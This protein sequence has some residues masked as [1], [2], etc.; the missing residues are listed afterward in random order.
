RTAATWSEELNIGSVRVHDVE[1]ATFIVEVFRRAM[2]SDPCSVGGPR[3]PTYNVSFRVQD[4]VRL[5]GPSVH[6]VEPAAR[7]PSIKRDHT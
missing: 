4:P 5:A 1:R 3:R 2:E 6:D 7:P